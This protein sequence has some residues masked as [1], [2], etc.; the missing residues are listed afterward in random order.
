MSAAAARVFVPVDASARSVGADQVAAALAAAGV[1][2]VRN[3]SRGLFR[4][5]P[6]VEFVT[7][8]GRI[9]Y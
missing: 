5:E 3:G 9:A 1:D 7:D 8:A 2:V 4:L 6:M